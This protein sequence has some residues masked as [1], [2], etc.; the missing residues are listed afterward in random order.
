MSAGCGGDGAEGASDGH[1]PS[2]TDAP[3]TPTT[4]PASTVPAPP[5]CPPSGAAVSVLVT[6]AAMGLRYMV[7]ALTNCGAEAYTV[8]GYPEIVLLDEDGQPYDAVE[9]LHGAGSVTGEDGYCTPSGRFDDGPQTVQ[10][11]PGEAAQVGVAWRNTTT[12]EFDLL[13]NAPVMAI[14]PGPGEQPQHLTLDAPV[15]L[16]T[17]G[18]LALSAWRPDG[19]SC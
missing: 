12:D 10:L 18:R 13:V 14:V 9:V 15:D 2:T 19:S 5:A 8:A 7:L 4:A 6:D 11:A 3:S 16:G 1:E 17:T